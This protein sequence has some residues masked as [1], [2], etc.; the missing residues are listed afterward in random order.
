[1]KKQHLVVIG[2]VLG[3]IAIIALYEFHLALKNAESRSWMQIDGQ[4]TQA[5]WEPKVYRVTYV[6]SVNGETFSS[7]RVSFVRIGSEKTSEKYSQGD[8]VV[9]FV[10]PNDHSQAVLEPVSKIPL[11]HYGPVVFLY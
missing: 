7:S 2:T 4:V 9:V 8:K 6:Y 11:S 3:L 1:M 10:N 5:I